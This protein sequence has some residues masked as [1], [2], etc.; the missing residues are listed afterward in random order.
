MLLTSIALILLL[1]LLLGR[2]ATWLRLPSLI[3]MIITGILLGPD[4]FNLIDDTLLSAASEV[5]LLALV[6]IV[7]RIGLSLNLDVVKKAGKPAVLLSFVP[8]ALEI[9]AITLLAPPILGIS[10]FEAAL[11]G[12]ILA[13]V[14]SSVLN[15]RL[16]ALMTYGY[17]QKNRVP[18]LLISSSS[19]DDIFVI[20]IF[21]GLLAWTD[22]G[23]EGIMRFLHVPIAIALGILVGRVVGTLLFDFFRGFHVRDSIKI[24]V[25][26]GFSLLL[27]E[28]EALVK[29]DY[30]FSGL[31]AVL[32]IGL[33][34]RDKHPLLADRLSTRFDR[35]WVA[36]EILLFVLAGATLDIQYV[37]Q[38]GLLAVL[39]I[40][41]GMTARLLG[42]YASL[43]GTKYTRK[44]RLFIM[45]AYTPKA[46]VQAA[47]GGTPLVLA[48][49]SGNILM[50]VSVI[51]ILLAAPLGSWL[52]D[53]TYRKL[54]EKGKP[55][56]QQD[57]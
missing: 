50:T 53:G 37:T 41:L 38:A 19:M 42:T 32:M 28:L 18:Q 36:G 34:I 49:A 55:A 21:T 13:S 16:L 52:I 11:L 46:S 4:V 48:L 6:L 1:G 20:V 35:L 45:F 14:A 27:L 33:V 44:E 24:L 26:L 47:L 17:G 9:G 10:V 54:L 56:E 12:A 43:I 8:S 2:M 23:Y 25:I 3:G 40:L 39:L 51:S 7:I 22:G 29:G 31:L 5:R 30:P 57:A 15:P